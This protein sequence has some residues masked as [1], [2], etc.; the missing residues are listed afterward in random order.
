MTHRVA[1]ASGLDIGHYISGIGHLGLLGWVALGSFF[2]VDPKPF[3]VREV[4]I[5]SAQEF[6]AMFASKTGTL[7]APLQSLDPQK[8]P[9]EVEVPVEVVDVNPE[10]PA[11]AR[12][13]APGS[14]PDKNDLSVV[15]EPEQIEMPP[16][17]QLSTEQVALLMPEVREPPT[18]KR[19]AKKVPKIAPAPE[20]ASEPEV[21]VE[22]NTTPATDVEKAAEIPEPSTERAVKE[23]AEVEIKIEKIDPTAIALTRS[24]RPKLRPINIAP[25][26]AHSV[27]LALQEAMNAPDPVAPAEQS[28]PSGPPMTQGERDS[29]Q[30]AVEACWQVDPGSRS[31]NVVITLAIDLTP[32]GKLVAGSLRMINSEGGS[33]DAVDTAFLKARGAVLRCKNKMGAN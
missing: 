30:L 21:A 26:Q 6:D 9:N 31:A 15:V 7:V 13:S 23:E 18:P 14:V 24:L 28:A 32:D 10:V 8:I 27:A 16:E 2:T 33:G 17:L 20:V 3:E 29:L 5:V 4:A 25:T 12:S 11:L 1:E 22:Q 19:V